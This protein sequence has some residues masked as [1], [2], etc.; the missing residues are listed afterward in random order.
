MTMP[1]R[2][3]TLLMTA[4]A[5]GGVWHYCLQLARSLHPRGVRT[6]LAVMGPSP[7]SAQRAQAAAVPGLVLECA[8]FPLEWMPEVGRDSLRAS[9]DWLLAL[10]RRYRP[11]VVQINGWAHAAEPFQAPVVLVAHSCVL[12]WWRAV[13]GCDAPADWQAYADRLSAGLAAATRVVAPTQAFLDEIEAVHGLPKGGRVIHNGREPTAFIPG[14]KDPIIFSAGRIWDEAKNVSALDAVAARLPWPVLI[15]GDTTAPDG[16]SEG[17]G[18]ARGLGV[19]DCEGLCEAMARAAIFALPARYEPFGL[20]AL[21]AALSGCAL[22]LGNIPTLRE[23][24]EGCAVFVDPDDH[25]GLQAALSELTADPVRREDLGQA[26]RLRA[27]RYSAAR[28]AD[29]YAALYAGLGMSVGAL[30]A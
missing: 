16:R 22:V 7:S 12:S 8:P 19:L 1:A 3:S 2:H 14:P 13:K 15:A 11:D 5:V 21:E 17:F 25:E 23:L 27:T 9:G 4:D 18:A 30:H 29:S 6:V 26:A 24:W 20:A 28:M 10:E